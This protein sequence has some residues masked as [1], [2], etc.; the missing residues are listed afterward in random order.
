MTGS[1]WQALSLF[2]AEF[3]Q[4]VSEWSGIAAD[5]LRSLQKAA[6]QGDTPPYPLETALVYNQ[7]LD[8]VTQADDIKLIVI[9]DNPGKD[10]QRARN[11]RYLV[12]QSGKVA[13][14]F[15]RRQAE[16]GI[17]F[18]RNA[19]ILNKTPVHTAKTRHLA[20]LLRNGSSAVRD[21]ILQSQLWMAERTAALHQAM[22]TAELWL[23]GYA[24]LKP[25]GIFVPYKERLV[26]SYRSG[27]GFAAA[28]QKVFVYQHFSMNCFIIDRNKF[29]MANPDITD[30]AEQLRRIGARH[31]AEILQ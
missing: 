4:K 29:C 8:E 13:D 23:V 17:D 1:Q 6:A 26:Q 2:R 19:L 31:K 14:G 28:W 11:R 18:R 27:G 10:E 5:E 15:F 16:L 30:T 12:G 22:A 9:G 24:E 7:A 21:L 20:Y 25:K 3:R